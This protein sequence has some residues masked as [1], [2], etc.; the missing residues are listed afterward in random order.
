[1]ILILFISIVIWGHSLGTGVSCRLAEIISKSDQLSEHDYLFKFTKLLNSDAKSIC[2]GVFLEAPFESIR[3]AAETHYIASILWITPK[4]V[5]NFILDSIICICDRFE[6]IRRINSIS[7]PIMIIHAR[8]D[9][10]ISVREGV[11]LAKKLCDSLF[12]PTIWENK[13]FYI[14]DGQNELNQPCRLC[15]L[16][17]GGHN[18]VSLQPEFEDS[19]KEFIQKNIK[20]FH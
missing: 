6:S 20:S 4:F 3:T 11:N 2:K 12:S 10:V 8:N 14:A 9:W 13:N 5:R 16:P 17:N 19:V 7:V 1:M 15:V 18:N